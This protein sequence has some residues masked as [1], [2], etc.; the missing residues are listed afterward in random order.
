MAIPEEQ[1]IVPL[2]TRVPQYSPIGDD[3]LS[4]V[5]LFLVLERRK[6][7]LAAVFAVIALLGVLYAV[8]RTPSYGYTSSIQIGRGMSGLLESPAAVAGK[9]NESYIPY[10]RYE[11]ASGGGDVPTIRAEAPKDSEIVVLRSSGPAADQARHDEAHRLVIEQLVS[12][13]EGALSVARRNL[14]A[15]VSRVNTRYQRLRAEYALIGERMA[16]LGER[17]AELRK[18][19]ESLR[20]A[21]AVAEQRREDLA[22]RNDQQAMSVLLFVDGD[23]SRMRERAQ[24]L[25]QELHIAV[26]AE[27]DAIKKAELDNLA[28]QAEAQEKLGELDSKQQLLRPSA[29][30]TPTVRSTEPGG[31]GKGVIVAAALVLG[32]AAGVFLAFIAEFL[33]RTRERRQIGDEV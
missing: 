22:Q 3:E 20:D 19:L 16:R 2:G 29:A 11:A 28:L 10:V 23:L 21:I 17:E 15:E 13:Q 31:P 1:R 25:S 27:R 18:A 26:A 12:D 32:L 4:L 7:L 30:M 33:A 6:R 5:D 9:L 8:M 24:Q 14:Q